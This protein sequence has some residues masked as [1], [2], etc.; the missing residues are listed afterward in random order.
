MCIVNKDTFISN[1]FTVDYLVDP[2]DIEE[3]VFQA[4]VE[5]KVCK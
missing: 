1:N 2:F 4:T 3:I 5:F